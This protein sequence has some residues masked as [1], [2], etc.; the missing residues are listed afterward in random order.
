MIGDVNKYIAL[1][2]QLFDFVMR[3]NARDE[4]LSYEMPVCII[5]GAQDWVC[6]TDMA[7]RYLESIDAPYKKLYIIDGCGHD[8][9][10]TY[11]KEFCNDLK[12]FL[13]EIK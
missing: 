2:K 9:H 5:Q 13:V 7:A 1:N 3:Y 6:P 4:G 11:P 12:E 8:V 10:C